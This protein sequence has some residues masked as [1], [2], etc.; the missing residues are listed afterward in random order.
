MLQILHGMPKSSFKRDF[1]S[2]VVG[3]PHLLIDLLPI[4]VLGKS[5]CMQGLCSKVLVLNKYFFTVQLLKLNFPRNKAAF[6]SEKIH[7]EIGRVSDL[8]NR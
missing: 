8:I 2:I 6:T 1:H 3:P 4:M 5:K 7:S